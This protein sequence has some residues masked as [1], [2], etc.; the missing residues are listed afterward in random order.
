M[1]VRPLLNRDTARGVNERFSFPQGIHPKAFRPVDGLLF[2]P[3]LTACFHRLATLV[4][5]GSR[6]VKEQ[7]LDRDMQ[8]ASN[9]LQGAAGPAFQKQAPVA[10]GDTSVMAICRDVQGIGLTIFLSPD[11]VPP[12]AVA[13]IQWRSCFRPS[14]SGSILSINQLDL[15][16]R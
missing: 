10:F 9:L 12:L 16:F 3:G 6:R 8:R 7:I 14:R 13:V 4:R 11:F 5:V 1:F 15:L 2:R